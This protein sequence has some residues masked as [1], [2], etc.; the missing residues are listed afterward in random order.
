MG[1]RK[2]LIVDDEK[3][4]LDFMRIRISNWGY[5]I[6]EAVNGKDALSALASQN[7]D[8]VVLDYLMPDMDGIEVLKEIRKLNKEIPV[9]MFTAHPEMKVIQ[10]AEKL[11][12]SAFIPKL[13]AYQDVDKSLKAALDLIEQKLNK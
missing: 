7:P 9:V 12:V 5:E 11:N 13:S 10:G 1:K 3:D 6:S 2:V 8:I 4:F